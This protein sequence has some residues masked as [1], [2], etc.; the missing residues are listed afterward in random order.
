MLALPLSRQS[1]LLEKDLRETFLPRP[2]RYCWEWAELGGQLGRDGWSGQGHE[3]EEA[4]LR[5]CFE[6]GGLVAGCGLVVGVLHPGPIHSSE[7]TEVAVP[8]GLV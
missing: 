1:H 8:W 4:E 6:A 2:H 7:L 3:N 5:G